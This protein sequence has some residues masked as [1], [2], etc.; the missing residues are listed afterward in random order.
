MKL[1]EQWNEI[2]NQDRPQVE[3]EKFW[4][5][6][7]A[8]EKQNYESILENNNS[9][10]KGIFK[11]LAEKYEMDTVT[12]AGFLD[13]INTSLDEALDLELLDE[14]SE[15]ELK[16][17]FKKL[18]YN[19]LNAKADW[20]YNLPQWE[21]ILSA[22]ERTEITKEFNRTRIAV[23]NKVGRNDPCPCGSGKKYK[24]CCGLGA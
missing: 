18:Y 5:S 23:S 1:I 6:Y 13:G 17:D 19:M 12:F 14:E 4:K 20:L 10:I 8:K 7:L 3:N 22:Q 15:L 24:K 21:N 9:E 16:I 11:E 2:A